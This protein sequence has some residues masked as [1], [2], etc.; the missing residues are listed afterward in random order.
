VLS[1]ASVRSASGAATYFAKDDYYTVEGSHEVSAWGGEGAASLGLEGE[2]TKDAFEAILNGVLPDGEKVGQ[3][4]NRQSGVDMTFS[5][6][7]SASVMAYVA[8]DKRVLTAN[9]TA[10]QKTMAWAEK[11]LAEGRKDVEG[12]KVPFKTGNLVYAL[13]QHDTSRSLDPQGHVHAVI[14]NLTRMPDGKMQALHNGS[15]WKSNSIIGSVYHAM[16]RTELEKIGYQIEGK[17]RHGTFEI[18]GVPKA[19]IDAFSQRR[20][21]ILQRAAELGIKSTQGLR[22]VTSRTRD[23]KLNVEDRTA[24][25]QTWI[26]RAKGLGFDGKGLVAG[27]EARAAAALN[28]GIAERGVRALTVVIEGARERVGMFLRPHDPL[29]DS[30][31]SRIALS[32]AEARTQLAVASAVRILSEREAAFNIHTLSKTAL[33][34][35]LKGVTIDQVERRIDTMMGN[36]QLIPE[37]V[38]RDDKTVQMVT[39]QE[40][41]R[42]EESILRA[43]EAGNGKA[44]P[45]IAASD[46]PARLQAV[47]ERELNPGQLAAATLILSSADRTVAIQG[48]AGAGK[49]TMLQAVARV[50]EAEG[51]GITGLAFQ[52]KMVADM[53]EASGIK[54]QTIASFVMANERF[55]TERDTP[56]YEAARERLAGTML[57][58]DETSMVSSH[59]MLKLHRISEAIGVDKVVL[60]GDRQQL[61]SIDAG[62]SFALIQAGGGTMARMDE[63]IRQRTDT[64][65][66]VAALANVGKAGAAMK[67]L[68]DNVVESGNPA[69]AAAEMWIGLPAADREATAVFA[70]G[71]ASRA[72]INQRIQDGLAAEG[73]VK[74]E[75]IHLIVYERVN[76]TREELRYASSY[77]PGQTLDVGRG[78][79]RDIGLQQGRYDVNRVLPNGKIELS[80][81]TR[82]IRFDPQKLSPTEKRDRLELTEKKDLQLREGDRIR[83]TANDKARD[84]HNA[85]LAR[86]VTVDASGVTVE[87]AG[88]Q[89]LTLDV[90]DPMLSRLD[91]AYSLNM[92]MAQGITT[93]KA[94]TVM[95]SQ[96]RN[97]S[98]QRLFNV[99]VTRVRDELTMVVDD[100]AKLERQLDMNPGN[101]TSALET[102]GR[103]DVDGR[104]SKAPEKFDPGPIDG[105]D[106]SPPPE[107]LADLPPLPDDPAKMPD[108]GAPASAAKGADPT[109]PPDLKPDRGDLL[110]PVPERSLGL[111]L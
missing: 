48:V 109:P 60:V 78:G 21:D 53:A 9:M 96:E 101:K 86:V 111:D 61:S 81:G 40:S 93:D 45:M 91:L 75:G 57:V 62:K 20:A 30:G 56:R 7:K 108:G 38:R 70:S 52:N 102:V 50:A 18:S 80:D 98:N 49:S 27:S 47:A 66:T 99:G 42:T 89:T 14:A 65:R 106:Q 1:I 90:G 26:D 84:L 94:I 104:R 76:M 58:V 44:S 25:K 85:A 32:P 67:V 33:D 95:S 17:G 11:N 59:D 69:L 51:R 87:T 97:L 82:K 35:G 54:S 71:R 3:V 103:L 100:K 24:L 8:G 72:V 16:L 10:V 92:H 31:L 2:I 46:A 36:R 39:T 19:V 41:L 83:W 73:T 107:L 74:G 77:R 34:L 22:D 68:G 29:V 64:L 23:P 6:P 37:M 63:N 13:F 79:A 5:M 28:N 110:P 12:K 105:V 55:V 88:K 43:L 4:E 15:L